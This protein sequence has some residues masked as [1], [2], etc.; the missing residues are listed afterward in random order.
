MNYFDKPKFYGI[1]II[2]LFL[3][4][5]GT[6]A[7][8]W[9]HRPHPPGPEMFHQMQ[10]RQGDGER[11]GEFLIHE[12]NL[13]QAQLADFI[14][15]RDEHQNTIKPA[16]EDIRKNK[17]EMFKMLSTPQVDSAKLNQYI[18][19]IAKDQKQLELATFTHFQ[20][21]RA[22]CDDSQKKK[23]DEIIGEVLKMMGSMQGPHGPPPGPMDKMDRRGPP[24][25]K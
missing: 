23:F 4:N 9:F 25:D 14:K 7:F 8:M 11:P 22:M 3:L 19:N 15:L 20:K 10:Y 5:L 1:I 18:D 13:S 16:A 12:L 6:L 2:L 24:D 17:D 21:V